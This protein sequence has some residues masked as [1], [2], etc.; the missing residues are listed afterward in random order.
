MTPEFVQS[1]LIGFISGAVGAVAVNAALAWFRRHR[2][3]SHENPGAPG[4]PRV[5]MRGTGGATQKGAQP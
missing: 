1:V 2:P 5:P 4:G 3:V